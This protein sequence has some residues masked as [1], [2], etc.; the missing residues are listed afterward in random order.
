MKNSFIEIS[1]KRYYE[2]FKDSSFIEKITDYSINCSSKD[3]IVTCNEIVVGKRVSSSYGCPHYAVEHLCTKKEIED[4]YKKVE[5]DKKY[6]RKYYKKLN[7]FQ[8]T[9]KK[10]KIKYDEWK[11][12]KGPGLCEFIKDENLISYNPSKKSFEGFINQM[13]D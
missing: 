6:H 9:L 7:I 1:R 13:K 10:I 11:S 3:Y 12:P 8:R 4:H 5:E 2:I